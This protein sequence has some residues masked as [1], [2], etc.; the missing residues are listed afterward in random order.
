MERCLV[1]QF[2]TPEIL[3]SVGFQRAGE[4]GGDNGMFALSG[5]EWPSATLQQG[6]SEKNTWLLS[7]EGNHKKVKFN[8][9]SLFSRKGP[10]SGPHW[11]QR[12]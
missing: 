9:R 3:F 4:V 1:L 12:H 7:Q 5:S 6:N 8:L 11:R 2:G 10:G